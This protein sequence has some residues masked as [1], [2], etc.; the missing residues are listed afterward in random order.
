[1]SASAE[2]V[3][4]PDLAAPTRRCLSPFLPTFAAFAVLSA[5]SGAPRHSDLVADAAA[6]LEAIRLERAMHRFDE[7]RTAKPDDAEAHRQYALLA[8]YFDLFAK[9]ADA[10]ERVLELEPG[11]AAAW[12][13]HVHA[14]R[15][16]GTMETDR[17]YGEKVLRILPDALRNASRRPALYG[18]A[19]EAAADLGRLDAYHAVL[20]SSREA[21]ADNP[22]LLHFLRAAQVA[23]ADGEEGDRSRALK[24]S[25]RGEL[26]ELAAAVRHLTVVAAPTLY[27][28]A[29]GYE[30]LGSGAEADFWLSRLL[31]APDRGILAE[32]LRYWDSVRRFGTLLRA[33]R[34]GPSAAEAL[35]EMARIVDEG[36]N[37]PALT[38]R[39][40]WVSRRVWLAA[41]VADR[42]AAPATA[43]GGEP[44]STAAEPQRPGL[45]PTYAEPLV[46]AVMEQ[47]AWQKGPRS[48]SLSRLL[49]YGLEPR[50]VREEAV[51]LEA[52]LRADRPG[53]LAAG[54]AG[55]ARERSRQSAI[56]SARILQARALAQL[57]ETEAAGRLFE[58]LATDFPDSRTLAQYG[59]HLV[60]TDQ[61][62]RGLDMLV[63]A[64]AHGGDWRRAAEEAAS[65]AGL[66]VGAVDD[67]LE[68]R[69]PIVRAE[70]EARALGEHLELEPPELAL[71]DRHGAE[72]ALGD[73]SGKVVVL[74]FWATWCGYSLAEFPHFAKLVEQHE[75][76]DEVAFLAVATAGS[77][78]E[79]VSD[80]LSESGSAFPILLD[81]EGKALD[82]DVLAYPTTFFLD[83]DG[84]I[85]F[86][87]EGFREDGYER[88]TV[89][90][91]DAL[92]PGAMRSPRRG[93]G[94]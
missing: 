66:P 43:Q 63:E 70:L 69:Q 51:N 47:I 89:I 45:S 83:P 18:N 88:R 30:F 19:R 74:K 41:A 50:R 75:D 36:M 71:A 62:Q 27:R 28:L 60:R 91:I 81:D 9:A 5:C 49:D 32:D 13:G 4:L 10:W 46:E 2:T 29:K 1:M 15:W 7:A 21:E 80:M 79:S 82:F 37:S 58:E 72:R 85:Q 77:S 12:E 35:E 54:R 59:R 68:V 34:D 78:R 22:V 42:F 64:L 52:A 38:R 31:A 39:A 87:T 14:L 23:I 24:D 94:S 33:L 73:L 92:R 8:Q 25:I 48:S 67:R 40:A 26:D 20:M 86:R 76:D 55:E 90:R 6:D 53:Y 84:L 17:R 11:D 65:A 93:S 16:A 56:T 61:P 3:H 57:G 44:V